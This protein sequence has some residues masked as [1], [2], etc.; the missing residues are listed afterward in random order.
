M[1]ENHQTGTVKVL[2]PDSS[3]LTQQILTKPFILYASVPCLANILSVVPVPSILELMGMPSSGGPPGFTMFEPDTKRT[4][5][6][7][8]EFRLIAGFIPG[9][10]VVISS[11]EFM[12]GQHLGTVVSA[13]IIV[14]Y[15]NIVPAKGGQLDAAL[16]KEETLKAF[17]REKGYAAVPLVEYETPEAILRHNIAGAPGVAGSPGAGASA[18]DTREPSR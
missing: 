15:Y 5:V 11:D 9:S 1:P 16:E 17:L 4:D 2:T 10:S 13:A 12:L 14:N 18:G 7:I 3:A 6:H 8:P